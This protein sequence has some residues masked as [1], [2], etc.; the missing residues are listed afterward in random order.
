VTDTLLATKIRIPPLHSNLVNRSHLIQRLNDGIAQNHCL[1]LVSAPAGY[2]KSTLLSEWVVQMDTPVAWL[3]LEK[4]ENIPTRFWNYFVTALSTIPQLQQVGISGRIPQ[5][6]RS[7]RSPSVEMLLVN[8]V[9]DLSQLKQK[10]ILVLDDLHV[11]MEG[12]IHQDLI[13]LIDHLPRSATSLHLVVASRMDPPWPLARWRVCDELTEM[14]VK[15]LRFSPADATTFLNDVMGLK[16]A[17]QDITLLEQRTEGWIAGLQMAALSMQSQGDI[18]GFLAGFTGTHR[19]VL[20]YLLEEVLSQQKPEVL[21][22]LLRTSLLEYLTAPLCDAITDSRDSQA[23]LL[24][25]EKSNMFL[26]PMDDERRWYRYHHLFSD[27][28]QLRL[29]QTNPEIIPVLHGKAC[30]WYMENGYLSNALT[31]AIAAND[32]D[33]LVKLIEKY[34]FTIFDFNQASTFLS[35][36]NTLPETVMESNPWLYIARAWLLAYLGQLEDIES[37]LVKAEKYA[38]RDDRRLMGYIAAMWTLLGELY[39]S[40]VDGISHAHQALTLLPQQ[41]Y[42]ARAF[43]VYHLSNHYTWYGDFL[44]ALKALEDSITWSFAAGD[45]ER[46]M[47]AQFQTASILF[48]MGRLRESFQL[49]KK[50]FQMVD[51]DLPDKKNRSLP[52]GYAYIQLSSLY[53]EWNNIP[54]ALRYVSDGIKICRLWG[55]SDYLHNGLIYYAEIRMALGDLEGALRAVREAKTLYSPVTVTSR[56]NSY[57]AVINQARGDME[58]ASAWASRCNLSPED[59][60]DYSHR[61]VY[62]H[63]A[64][65]LQAQGKLQEAYGILDRLGNIL[66]GTGAIT[67]LLETISQ[68]IIILSKLNEHEQALSLLQRLLELA[69]PEGYIRVFTSKGSQM[70][71]LLQS[72]L[73]RGI[74]MEYIKAL[75]PAFDISDYSLEPGK[76]LTSKTGLYLK[77]SDSQEPLSERELQV[78]LLLDSS[79]SSTE[80]GRELYL[81]VNTIRTHIR[82]I[83]SKLAVHGRIEAIRKA[84]QSG[85]I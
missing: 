33:R 72:A 39:S 6:L 32:L 30:M 66:E 50:T 28:L 41:E 60:I 3:S 74:E 48:Y 73:N 85:L 37:L 38:D 1:T 22:F 81:S 23:M 52:V 44:P 49:F 8:L 2:G 12:Q 34:A 56:A 68:R 4:G 63:Y 69:R 35:W 47:I 79:L 83:Y 19:F 18:V 40:R 31:H 77:S 16:L 25:L 82:N 53:F 57:E 67:M 71:R 58:S 29:K 64:I 51:S 54:E 78:L 76:P 9:N 61:I 10:V 13:F 5:S 42:R 46:A 70:L 7:R 75:I 11:I 36:L 55:Y 14:R 21:N 15:D 59:T 20:D 24:R 17:T 26:V 62:L 45:S 27:M 65:I 43:V 84:K 80:I